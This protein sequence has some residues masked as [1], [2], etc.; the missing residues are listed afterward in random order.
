MAGF[1]TGRPKP[2]GVPA[3]MNK[4]GVF[5][6]GVGGSGS[7]RAKSDAEKAAETTGYNSRGASAA[8]G[9]KVAKTGPMGSGS[10]TAQWVGTGK[11]KKYVDVPKANADRG[12][13]STPLSTTAQNRADAAKGV[14][15]GT[16]RNA[17]TRKPTKVSVQDQGDSRGAPTRQQATQQKKDGAP[18]QGAAAKTGASASSSSAVSSG[19]SGKTAKSA[20]AVPGSLNFFMKKA[21]AAGDKN[22]KNRAYQMWKNSKA[23]KKKPAGMNVDKLPSNPKV[24]DEVKGAKGV[25]WTWTG[26]RWKRGKGLTPAGYIGSAG[27]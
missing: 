10:P 5:A 3:G 13:V 1:A 18:T 26:G 21:A 9:S 2:T 11:D 20:P 4:S 7:G 27:Q 17:P 8:R 25:T 19:K 15:A 12:K 24:G 6:G 23:E 16:S 14:N 22:V